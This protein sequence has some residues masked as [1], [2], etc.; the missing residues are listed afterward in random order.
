MQSDGNHFDLRMTLLR[1][2]NLLMMLGYARRGVG[3]R[4]KRLL[5]FL[6]SFG[7]INPERILLR[8]WFQDRIHRYGDGKFV[9][10]I[11]RLGGTPVVFSLRQGN[12]GD[13][14][15]GSEF[16][17]DIYEIP[18][19]TPESILDGGA[20][21][22][23]FS[24]F[25]SAMFPRAR[26]ICYEPDPANFEQLQRNLKVNGI[27]SEYH[28]AGLWKETTTLYY[29]SRTSRTGFV[30]EEPSQVTIPCIRPEIGPNCWLKLDV[31]TAEYEILPSLLNAGDYPRWITMEIH[32]YKSRGHFLTELLSRHGYTLKGG[33]DK[34]VS[35]V[36]VSA[37]RNRA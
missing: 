13:Y 18:D 37:F 24:I 5:F 3:L 9:E 12:E 21:I 31:E 14:L 32:H 16:A 15:V 7:A 35:Y 26:L 27:R 10:V 19:F 36:N 6:A 30:S 25:A 4:N 11:L 23:L 33:E 8:H 28:R 20:N 29:H 2:R 34:S 22:G 1:L 17:R